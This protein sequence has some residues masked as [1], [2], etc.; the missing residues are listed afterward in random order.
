[1]AELLEK[2]LVIICVVSDRKV[3]ELLL[4]VCWRQGFARAH[5]GLKFE[6]FLSQLLIFLGLQEHHQASWEGP[7]FYTN[8][9]L[10]GAQ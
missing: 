5:T 8:E 3:Q 9:S 2:Q 10:V 6:S 4:L 7:S 1:M